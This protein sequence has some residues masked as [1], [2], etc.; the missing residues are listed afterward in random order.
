LSAT[1]SRTLAAKSPVIAFCLRQFLW[2][3]ARRWITRW[4]G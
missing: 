1:Q 3:D 4:N 2:S